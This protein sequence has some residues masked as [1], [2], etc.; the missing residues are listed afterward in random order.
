MNQVLAIMNKDNIQWTRRPLYFIASIMLAI[1]IIWVVGDT[2]AGARGIPFGL[3]DPAGISE[4][5]RHVADSKRFKVVEYD[6][7]D[8][9]KRDLAAGKIVVLADVAQDPL[10]DE[11][12][13]FTEGHNP[14]V[15]LQVSTGILNVLTSRDKELSLPLHSYSLFPVDFAMRDYVTPGLAAYLCYVLASMNLGF[16]WIYEWWEKTYRQII[17]APHGLRSAIIAKTVNVTLEASLVLWMA[18]LITAPLGGYSLGNNFAGLVGFTLLSMFCF[19]C[20]GLG[21]ACLLKT[22][23]IY[24][25]VVSILGV[26]LMFISGIVIPV[27]AMP[28]GWQVA[29][30]ALPMYYS[31]D[32]FKGVMLGTPARY[33]DDALMLI[34]WAGLGLMAAAVLL[35]RRRAHL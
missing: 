16:S 19:T 18:L 10:E 33:F 20:L 24:T 4:L 21:A 23:R 34:A 5:A 28:A 6:D 14:L 9:G 15:G 26:G 13:I 29:A 22:I 7:I 30:K 31:A 11:V 32:A 1:L 17:L 12:H 25:M 2:I 27:E 35:R 8:Q 3:Y